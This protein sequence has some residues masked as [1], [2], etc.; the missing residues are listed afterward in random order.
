MKDFFRRPWRRWTAPRLKPN[1]DLSRFLFRKEFDATGKLAKPDPFLPRKGQ[2]SVFHTTGLSEFLVWTLGEKHVAAVRK[3][4]LLARA[5]IFVSQ[6]IENELAIDYDNDPLRHANIVGWPAD[7]E[8]D[9]QLAIAMELAAV[10][11][12][13]IR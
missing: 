2:T 11:K 8:Y 6:V 12:L 10:A 5:D 1:D 9:R 13:H 7:D 3:R 4:T